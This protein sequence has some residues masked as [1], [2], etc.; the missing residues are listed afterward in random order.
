MVASMTANKSPLPRN[1]IFANP[2]ATNDAEHG[3][4]ITLIP[5]MSTVR[6]NALM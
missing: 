3:T 6:R 5:T 2:Y 1:L 4:T